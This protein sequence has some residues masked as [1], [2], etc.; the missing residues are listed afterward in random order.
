MEAL[1]KAEVSIH[2]VCAGAAAKFTEE[3]GEKPD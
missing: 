1:L 2:S 3:N